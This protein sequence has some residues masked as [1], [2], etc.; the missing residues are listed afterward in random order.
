VLQRKTERKKEQCICEKQ[1]LRS[2]EEK[3]TTSVCVYLSK[4][5]QQVCARE[6]RLLWMKNRGQLQEK[7]H[8]LWNSCVFF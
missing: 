6:S 8:R 4:L 2:I 1:T 7:K 3:D 5:K